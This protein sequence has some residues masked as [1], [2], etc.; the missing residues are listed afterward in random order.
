MF[1][2]ISAYEL[3]FVG[4]LIELQIGNRGTLSLFSTNVSEEKLP[5]DAKDVIFISFFGHA[6]YLTTVCELKPLWTMTFDAH[7]TSFEVIVA[8][9]MLTEM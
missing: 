5:Y 2:T 8:L 4:H 1:S 7:N 9:R 6:A 3:K